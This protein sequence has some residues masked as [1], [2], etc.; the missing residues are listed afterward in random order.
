MSTGNLLVQL[1]GQN[2]DAEREL[3]RGCPEGDLSED[4]VG[5]GA[6]HDEG[7][8]SSGAPEVNEAAFGEEDNVP[9][10]RHG[11]PVDLRFDVDRGHGVLLQPSDVNLNV[12][13]TDVGDDSVLGHDLEVLAGDDVPVTSGSNE[14][15]GARGGVL[16]GS[17]FETGHSSLES[18]DRVDLGDKNTSTKRPQRLGA[19]E[20]VDQ[21][22]LGHRGKG[23]ATYA[24]TDVPESSNNGNL[25]SKHDIGSTFDTVNEGLAASIVVIELALGNRVVDVDSSDLKLAFLVP[26]VEVVNTCG[27]FFGE[28]ADAGEKLRVL[29]V[30]EV[31]EVTTVIKDQ[32]QGLAAGETLDGLVDTP[33]V[34]LLG[35]TLPG[36]DRDTGGGDGSSSMVLSGEDILEGD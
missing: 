29:V 33:K 11:E 25:S 16:H 3:L 19:L 22:G 27:R 17:D 18:V 7:R 30:N 6:G 13:V 28:T 36:E 32:V 4:L 31:C 34:F 12:K 10:G 14:D 26:A 8:V 2:V 21:N 24:F 23:V 9:A 5:E 1:L 35:L 20:N 15:V